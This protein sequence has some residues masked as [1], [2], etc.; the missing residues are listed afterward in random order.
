[1]ILELKQ[2]NDSKKL[3]Q[4]V[5]ITPESSTYNRILLLFPSP[6]I[7]TILCLP[8]CWSLCIL[9]THWFCLSFSLTAIRPVS[10]NAHNSFPPIYI[11]LPKATILYSR[12]LIS[13]PSSLSAWPLVCYRSVHTPLFTRVQLQSTQLLP[14]SFW[15]HWTCHIYCRHISISIMAS[16][17]QFICLSL[18]LSHLSAFIMLML[19]EWCS[20]R[21]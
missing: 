3:N 12:L 9:H 11:K 18:L 8:L 5:L 16:A 10:D 13:Q 20:A 2:C 17:V 7:N 1:M 4:P 6:V 14:Q 15:L 19:N 21:F